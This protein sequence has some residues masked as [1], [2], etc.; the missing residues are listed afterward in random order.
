MAEAMARG[1]YPGVAFGSRSLSTDYEPV[2]SPAN[3][4]AQL[5]MRETFGIDTSQHRSQLLERGAVNSAYAI[6]CVTRGHLRVV[7]NLFPSAR[8]KCMVLSEDVDDPWRQPKDVY[9]DCANQLHPLV[10]AAVEKVLHVV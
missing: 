4:T 3:P 10:L 1:A 2:G 5:V 9:I 7:N 6:I 8:A